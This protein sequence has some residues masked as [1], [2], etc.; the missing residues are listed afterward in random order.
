M[1]FLEPHQSMKPVKLSM[2]LTA[3]SD[4]PG[5]IR[6]S[7]LGYAGHIAMQFDW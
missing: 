1:T 3:P 7:V 6:L 5:A 2:R 4:S